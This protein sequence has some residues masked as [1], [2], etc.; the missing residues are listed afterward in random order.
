MVPHE[1]STHLMPSALM[2]ARI[3][4]G[5]ENFCKDRERNDPEQDQREMNLA[6][7]HTCGTQMLQNVVQG[8]YEDDV[9]I[10]LITNREE[11]RLEDCISAQA[12]Q[13]RERTRPSS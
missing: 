13:A 8:H 5:L 9:I 3:A 4:K 10:N 2:Q 1:F 11:G 12:L 7:R 6:L